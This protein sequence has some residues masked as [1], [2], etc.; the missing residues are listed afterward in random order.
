MLEAGAHGAPAVS[1]RVTA[2]DA[3]GLHSIT[4]PLKVGQL[5]LTRGRGTSK[6]M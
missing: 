1:A 4:L 2:T 5:R 3:T 6:R